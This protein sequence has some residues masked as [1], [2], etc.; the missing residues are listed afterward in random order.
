MKPPKLLKTDRVKITDI[1]VRDRLRPVSEAGVASLIASIRETGVMKDAIH[2]RQAKS[3]EI[4]LMAGAH[5][6]EAAQRLGWED[7]EAKVWADVQ[8]DWALLIEIDD[9]LAGAEMDA[10]DTALFLAERKRVYEKLHPE[11]RADTFS[12]NQHTGKLAADIMSFA[13]STAEKFGVTERHVR[14]MVAAGSALSRDE[15][16][17][18]RSAPKPVTLADLQA[19][20]KVD[21]GHERA[22]IC[23]ALSNGVARSVSAARQSY[24]AACGIV[25]DRLQDP[26]EEA[27]KALNAAWGRAPMATRRRFV[28]A[29]FD[30]LSPLVVDAAEA[31]DAAE[32]EDMRRG[33]EAAE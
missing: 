11:A 4:V 28:D 25:S 15:R 32:I 30:D 20:A 27:L 2:V 31:R 8:N 33:L 1:V 12:G 9:N 14:R 13:T 19:L 7:V 3:G 23:I 5:R 26:V 24:A 21:D 6:V 17:W 18:L 29:V 22:Q 10:L 16:R